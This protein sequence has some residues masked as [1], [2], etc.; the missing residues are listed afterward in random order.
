MLNIYPLYYYFLKDQRYRDRSPQT[1]LR[2]HHHPQRSRPS[3]SNND[4]RHDSHV[5]LSKSTNLSNHPPLKVPQKRTSG[6][7][8]RIDRGINQKRS[9]NNTNVHDSRSATTHNDS[10]KVHT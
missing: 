10:E 1:R 5:Q 8:D 3:Q 4:C 6:A 7:H 9:K 2:D